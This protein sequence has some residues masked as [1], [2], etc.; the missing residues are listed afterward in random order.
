MISTVTLVKRGTSSSSSTAGSSIRRTLYSTTTSQPQAHHTGTPAMESGITRHW[1]QSFHRMTL[2]PHLFQASKQHTTSGRL[3]HVPRN[4]ATRSYHRSSRAQSNAALVPE[5]GSTEL[6]YVQHRVSDKITSTTS[7]ASGARTTKELSAK[8]PV[9]SSNTKSASTTPVKPTSRPRPAQAHHAPLFGRHSTTRRGPFGGARHQL[10]AE[11]PRYRLR[12]VREEPRRPNC[13]EFNPFM[14]QPQSSKASARLPA[15]AIDSTFSEPNALPSTYWGI[16]SLRMASQN[17]SALLRTSARLDHSIETPIT[18]EEAVG[19]FN[20]GPDMEVPVGS[21]LPS[22][23]GMAKINPEALSKIIAPELNPYLLVD[24]FERQFAYS[25]QWTDPQVLE[26]SLRRIG[27]A[28][29][30]IDGVPTAFIESSANEED[31]L[32]MGIHA[33]VSPLTR[34]NRTPWL[35]L[36]F[37]TLEQRD[38]VRLL[39]RPVM[40]RLQRSIFSPAAKRWSE[41]ESVQRAR[42]R[43]LAL[44]LQKR[45]AGRIEYAEWRTQ[46]RRFRLQLAATRALGSHRL[47]DQDYIG[48]MVSCVKG[49]QFLELELAVQHYMESQHAT[50]LPNEAI[51]Q[52]YLKGLAHQ[53]RMDHA[54]E[55]VQS[56]KRKG[57]S[58]SAQTFGIMLEGYGRQMDERRIKDTLTSMNNAG[59]PLTVEMYTSMM[60]NYIRADKLDEAQKVFQELNRS[61]L[62]LDSRSRNVVLHLARLRGRKDAGHSALFRAAMETLSGRT[63]GVLKSTDVSEDEAAVADQIRLNTVIHFNHHLKE[64]A[65]AMDTTKFVKKFKEMADAGLEPNTTSYNILVD[66]LSHAGSPNDGF[67]VLEHMKGTL[68]G[69]PDAVTYTTLID[70][71]VKKGEVE[72]GWGLYDEMMRRLIKPTLH[73]YGTLIDLVGLDPRSRTGRGI[74]KR[75]FIPGREHIRFPVK[76]AIEDRIGLNFAGDLYNQ[77][78]NQ[79]LKPSQHIFGGLLDLTVRGGF[80]QL[81]QHVY[82]EMINKS[83]GPNTAIMTTLIKGFAIQRDFDS[84]WKVWRNMVESNI[85]RN[86]I[87]YYHLIRLCERSLPNPIAMAEALEGS[88]TELTSE[89]SLTPKPRR[90]NNKRKTKH[91]DEDAACV[92]EPA[93]E[94][95]ENT[96]RIPLPIWTEIMDQMQVDRVQWSRVQQFRRKHVDR[97]VWSPVVKT[98]GAVRAATPEDSTLSS[99]A[100]TPSLSTLSLSSDVSSS[101]GTPDITESNIGGEEQ[102]LQSGSGTLTTELDAADELDSPMIREIYTGGGDL[103]V[104]RRVPSRKSRLVWDDEAKSVKLEKSKRATTTAT[105]DPADAA[106]L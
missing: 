81:A 41:P 64:S 65:D 45:D 79:G 74:V 103:F 22:K 99:P 85:P 51:Y 101:I 14:N 77:L 66:Y 23:L 59:H 30:M 53:G 98:V 6:N 61:G 26:M 71:A 60:S 78:C 32:A 56:M 105:I 7:N 33:V 21:K 12:D 9:P 39:D 4:C 37:D 80:M 31:V 68:R 44:A 96:A 2:H 10:A 93:R 34:V 84:G 3:T 52:M 100:S 75:H 82:L 72:L 102:E 92:T 13:Q 43:V 5:Y 38:W 42:T 19:V 62:K 57:L 63:V 89:E 94:S 16:N 46:T 36:L 104:P 70:C 11:P 87:T 91:G 73:T 50:S 47:D 29:M 54:Q 55:V 18:L 106:P 8:V 1:I 48:F 24:E 25:G 83:V 69:R 88:T 76:T 27:K 90:R 20:A 67:L 28:K 15:N 97:A 35:G 49:N 58:L 86:A 17:G 40:L 95:L